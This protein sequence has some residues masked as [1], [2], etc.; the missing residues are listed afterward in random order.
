[1]LTLSVILRDCQEAQQINARV[2]LLDLS[3]SGTIFAMKAYD[4]LIFKFKIILSKVLK[5]INRK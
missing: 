1:M 3:P 2:V 5:I 4:G